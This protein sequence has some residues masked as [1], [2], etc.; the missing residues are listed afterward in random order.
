MKTETWVNA[1]LNGLSE[2][3]AT[4]KAGYKGRPP[5][6]A[7]EMLADCENLLRHE[8]MEPGSIAHFSEHYACELAKMEAKKKRLKRLVGACEILASRN[9]THEG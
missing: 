2:K 7:Y 5:G 8:A 1:R 6:R 9:A 4:D 3:E